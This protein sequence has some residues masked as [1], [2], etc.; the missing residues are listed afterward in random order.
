MST[1]IVGVVLACSLNLQQASAEPAS[2]AGVTAGSG[3]PSDA[4]VPRAF[5][6]LAG[7]VIDLTK[8]SATIRVEGG[9]E[10]QRAQLLDSEGSVVAEKLLVKPPRQPAPRA[11]VR[12]PIRFGT[13]NHFR[14]RI[15]DDD[16]LSEARDFD[17]D[18]DVTAVDPVKLLRV[19]ATPTGKPIIQVEG[20]LGARIEITNSRGRVVGTQTLDEKADSFIT[21]DERG[22]DLAV[23]PQY[24]V[25]QKFGGATST[26][27]PFSRFDYTLPPEGDLIAPTLTS[28]ETNDWGLTTLS[29]D[30]T[31]APDDSLVVVKDMNRKRLAAGLVS[32][33]KAVVEFVKR[34]SEVQLYASVEVLATA[35]DPQEYESAATPVVINAG[36]GTQVPDAPSIEKTETGDARTTVTVAAEPG[37][38]VTIRDENGAVVAKRL[39]GASSTAVQLLVPVT[40]RTGGEYLVYQNNGNADSTPT[41]FTLGK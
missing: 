14:L 38:L 29:F 5:E 25:V 21:I 11:I 34:G 22:E 36:V 35:E 2:G 4:A 37:G 23:S 33:G 15:K 40:A 32:D 20:R 31:N 39:V 24:T 27:V 13:V 17:V 10:G 3:A 26:P 41:A 12:T 18:A 28:Q 16:T 19:T 9:V 30:A 8:T 7:T 1:G 6:P